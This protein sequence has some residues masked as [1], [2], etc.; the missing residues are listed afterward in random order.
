MINILIKNDYCQILDDENDHIFLSKLDMEL[1]Y[2]VPGCEYSMAFKLGRWDGVKRILTSTCQFP[3]GLLTRVKNFCTTQNKEFQLQDLRTPKSPRQ[4][5][6]ILPKLESLGKKPFDYQLDIL[7]S[8]KNND[9]GII[10][11]ATGSGK[12]LISAL[13]TAYFGKTTILY[14]IGND[15]LYQTHKFFTQVF[16]QEIGIIGDGLCQIENFNIASVWTIGKALGIKDK[17]IL[18]DD[19]SDEKDVSEDKYEDIRNLLKSTKV[20]I[21]D[22]C[23][24]CSCST[25]QEIAKNIRPEHIYGL[26]ASPHRDDNSDLLIESFLG[27]KITD[28][29]A[30]YLIERGYLTR[31]YIKFINVPKY[32]EKLKKNYQTI[33]KKYI[34]ENEVRNDLVVKGALKLVEQGY[35]TL[36]LFSTIAHG[37]KLYKEI[38]KHIPCILLSGKDSSEV[39][40][41]A[42]TKLEN[43][44]IN[45]LVAS[46]ILDIGYDLPSLS[47]LVLAG[48]GK[49]SVR[50]IQR[51]GRVIRKS[52]N[53]TQT[54]VIDFYDNAHYL[55]DHSKI[56]K[57]IY[58]SEPAFKLI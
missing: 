14:V 12:S 23:H 45:C 4:G 22:E 25:I 51:I 16:N 36:V 1:S 8:A 55:K 48:G 37:D 35:Q 56:R 33:Y 7:E 28:I 13:I 41:N 10:R 50:T 21:L 27:N 40:L 18:D 5:I 2:R 31:P 58:M 52:I 39:R 6:D 34:V 15:L 38:S 32:P 19:G 26:S 47:G 53:K 9:I 29:S 42:K 24:I 44:E 49:S 17:I 43:K 20:H 11:S 54:A 57:Q 3:Y 30:S 46:K